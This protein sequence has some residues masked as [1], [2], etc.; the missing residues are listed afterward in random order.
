MC[1]AGPFQPPKEP[2]LL[3]HSTAGGVRG[4]FAP[5]SSD[6]PRSKRSIPTTGHPS[7]RNPPLP[8]FT[9]LPG[10]SAA[11][12]TTLTILPRR[13]P[14]GL[15][16]ITLRRPQRVLPDRLL[17]A[18]LTL[19]LWLRDD[20]PNT[21]R[22]DPSTSSPRRDLRSRAHGFSG[23]HL[24]DREVLFP[25][26]LVDGKAARAA[27]HSSFQCYRRP[28]RDSKPMTL[29]RI[30]RHPFGAGETCQANNK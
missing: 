17:P 4:Q 2:N 8:S 30:G 20:S 3:P 12:S 7:S 28:R 15:G 19:C 13:L 29:S 6:L 26:L 24:S 23:R 1:V 9:K 21:I 27:V 10:V 25:G 18:G 11:S 5:C 14:G 16:E 22:P